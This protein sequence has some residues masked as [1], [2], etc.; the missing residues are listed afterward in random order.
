MC[1]DGIMET[2]TAFRLVEDELERATEKFG[3]FN[4]AHE[5][6]AVIL[7]EVDELW[8]EVKK[9]RAENHE[10]ISEA[11]QTA[12]MA[13]RFLIDICDEKQVTAHERK[14]RGETPYPVPT[15]SYVGYSG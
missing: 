1:Y 6:Y 2:K 13:I 15:R 12:A 4:T 9:G 5:G 3:A 7:E 11:V 10:G 8:D 14:A